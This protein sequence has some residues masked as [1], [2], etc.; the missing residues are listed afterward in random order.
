MTSLKSVARAERE[1]G[2]HERCLTCDGDGWCITGEV[3]MYG[4]EVV[5]CKECDRR[6]AEPMTSLKNRA[7]AERKGANS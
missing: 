2:T 1:C 4:Y 6:G 7:R 3:R 5:D